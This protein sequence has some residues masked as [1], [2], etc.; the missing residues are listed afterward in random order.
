MNLKNAYLRVSVETKEQLE[1]LKAIGCDY[2]QGYY[3]SKPL[4]VD[5]FENYLDKNN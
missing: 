4:P 5:E 1:R 2:I 3:Y